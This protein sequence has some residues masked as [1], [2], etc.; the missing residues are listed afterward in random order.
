M[1]FET[2]KEETDTELCSLEELGLV[3]ARSPIQRTSEQSELSLSSLLEK[4]EQLRMQSKRKANVPL[5]QEMVFL[6][7]EVLRIGNKY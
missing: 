3:R 7:L 1:Q 4:F 2:S 5:L 6:Y